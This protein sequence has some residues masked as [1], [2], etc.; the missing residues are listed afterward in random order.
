MQLVGA[1]NVCVASW[2]GLLRVLP[3]SRATNFHVA[4]SRGRFCFWQHENLVEMLPNVQQAIS[5]WNA[6]L[7]RTSSCGVT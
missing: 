7:W 5:T 2:G 4:E 3:P 6:T 1:A